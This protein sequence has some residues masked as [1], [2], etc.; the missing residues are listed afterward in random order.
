M[1][2]FETGLAAS[3][4][5][6]VSKARKSF[7]RAIELDSSFGAAYLMRVNTATTAKEYADD[8]AAGRAH[9]DSTSGWAKMYGEYLSTNL[10]G[11]RNKGIT[12]LEKIASDYPKA[13]RAQVDLGFAYAGNNQLDKARICFRKAAEINPKSTAAY[14]AMVNDYLFNDP[15]D[16][17]KAEAS[18]IKLVE[19]AP[20][21]AGA[22]VILGDCYRAQNDFA[23]AKEAYTK[24][25]SL[26]SSAAEAYYKAGHANTYLGKLDEARKNYTDAG[27]RDISK[28][29]SILNIAYT[30][31]YGNDPKTAVKVLM[32]G[33][34]KLGA[35]NSSTSKLASEKNNCLTTAANIAEHY[36]DAT[37]L[38]QLVPA[39]MPLSSQF[40]RDLGT[41]EGKIFEQAENLGWQTRIAIAEGNLDEAK[42]KAAE[43]KAAVAPLN[44]S[45]KEEDYYYLIGVIALKEK[46][47]ADAIAN[48]EKGDRNRIYIKYLLAKANE[49]AG[50]KDKA[51]ALYKEVASY[52]FNDVGNALVRNEVAKKVA[53]L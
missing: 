6:D 53:T 21:S 19:M 18:A 32:D 30:Y 44:D 37:Q 8:I 46:K 34:A 47:Y 51:A 50:N 45:R 31:L 2:A 33:A 13:A 4:L 7:T 23:K 25:I 1:A 40:Y 36:N 3:D 28:S 15:K 41:A 38:K 24:A 11:D 17:K 16:L 48:L 5:G 12:I 26:D 43:M 35:V 42:A 10:T 14:S 29:Y 20:A 9:V 27:Q 39:I 49:A 52:N 22:Q